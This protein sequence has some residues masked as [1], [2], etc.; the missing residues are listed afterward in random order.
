MNYN[1]KKTRYLCALALSLTALAPSLIA[2]EGPPRLMTYQGHLMD[3]SGDALGKT[4]PVNKLIQFDIFAESD[5]GDS[6]WGE[7]QTVTVDNGYFSVILGEGDALG[8][9]PQ[10]D[11][12]FIGMDRANQSAAERYIGITVDGVA[13]NPRLRLMTS[14]FAALS[15]EAMVAKQADSA[16]IADVATTAATATYEVPKKGIILWPTQETPPKGWAICNGG[17]GTPDLRERFVYGAAGTGTA[18]FGTRGGNAYYTLQSKHMPKHN[19]TV[20]LADGGQHNHTASSANDTHYHG[21]PTRN[22]DYNDTGGPPPSWGNGD[23]GSYSSR[24]NTA[25]DTHN[26]TI[27]VNNSSKHKH[28]ATVAQT[29]KGEQFDNRPSYHAMHYIMRVGD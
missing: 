23:N 12:I 20:T 17:S 10:H 1:Q 7:T 3:L 14:P 6:L 19:H 26:H 24:W 18:K 21:I 13:V 8:E 27:T 15:A 29:G 2:E 9:K 28:T 5:G 22:D 25:N 11:D 4:A 16:K